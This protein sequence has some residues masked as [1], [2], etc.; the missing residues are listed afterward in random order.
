M[1]HRRSL[2]LPNAHL[3]DRE[4]MTQKALAAIRQTGLPQPWK[5]VAHLPIKSMQSFLTERMKIRL[6]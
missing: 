6:Q 3:E 2:T 1:D 5:N 4:R